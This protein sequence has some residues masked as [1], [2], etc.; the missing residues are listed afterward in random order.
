MATLSPSVQHTTGRVVFTLTSPRAT[1]LS[2]LAPVQHSALLTFAKHIAA[3][4]LVSDDGH[5]ALDLESL[6]IDP[7]RKFIACY[8]EDITV[9]ADQV[10][11]QTFSAP[12]DTN[13]GAT[14]V[15]LDANEQ[16]CFDAIQSGGSRK[17]RAFAGKLQSQGHIQGY[18]QDQLSK[19]N[20][21]N[22]ITKDN[23]ARLIAKHAPTPKPSLE[24]INGNPP[25][26]GSEPLVGSKHPRDKECISCE[27]MLDPQTAKRCQDCGAAQT[28]ATTPTRGIAMF[29]CRDRRC[30]ATW[31]REAKMCH[32]CGLPAKFT[33]CSTPSSGL[34]CTECGGRDPRA[35]PAPRRTS[36]SAGLFSTPPK[37]NTSRSDIVGGHSLRGD[38]GVEALLRS[39]EHL[40]FNAQHPKVAECWLALHSKV[41]ALYVNR[42]YIPLAAFNKQNPAAQ[43]AKI[44][45][46]DS[47]SLDG[48]VSATGLRL[49]VMT[50]SISL[51]P[52]TTWSDFLASQKTLHL[53]DAHLRADRV[54]HNVIDESTLTDISNYAR[55][56]DALIWYETAAKHAA[57]APS[58]GGVGRP[59][60]AVIG[61]WT[62]KALSSLRANTNV[63]P[64]TPGADTS[65]PGT[66]VRTPQLQHQKRPQLPQPMYIK[67]K[68]DLLCYSF[69]KAGCHLQDGHDALRDGAPTK[70]AHRCVR[71]D[72]GTHGYGECPLKSP[73]D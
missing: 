62:A 70:V 11:N 21:N 17:L 15:T 73:L 18:S 61:S 47:T 35:A 57:Y 10:R 38:T 26:L 72:S 14:A 59:S 37:T 34:H 30:N 43:L 13:L 8:A 64:R 9:T 69:N 5:K 4:D 49:N 67:A 63:F 65:H 60:P 19:T 51:P 24:D 16:A 2:V 1:F 32:E 23:I 7:L 29:R 31:Q 36:G 54:H 53:L 41:R 27:V 40:A 25:P 20:G 56:T 46:N 22:K 3:Q 66:R 50:S 45:R 71:C 48:A 44:P 55:L 12:L 68:A 6:E 33:C 39:Y 42:K 58:Y 52:I 28:T